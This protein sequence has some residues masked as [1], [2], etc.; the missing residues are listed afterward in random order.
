M[1]LN[2]IATSLILSAFSAASAGCVWCLG[3]SRELDDESAVIQKAVTEDD[4]DHL[5][6]MCFHP[7]EYGACNGYIRMPVPGIAE[8]APARK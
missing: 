8:R 4:V 5:V 7:E 2:I 3:L 6:D 1:R